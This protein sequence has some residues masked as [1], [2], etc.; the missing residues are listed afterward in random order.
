ME[1][2]PQNHPMVQEPIRKLLPRFAIPCVISL[3]ISCLLTS[4]INVGFV[5]NGIGYLGNAAT[6]II[7]PVTVIG[8]GTSFVRRWGGGVYQ[9]GPGESGD[10][11]DT[12][13]AVAIACSSPFCPALS[14][15]SFIIWPVTAC[16][17]PWGNGY[18][19]WVDRDYGTIM[20]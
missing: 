6:G 9:P 10:N 14:L 1:N 18:D 4:W 2:V 19:H 20:P 12:G 11:H 16:S 3:I 13:R 15:R 5:G 8:W 17:M 7:F